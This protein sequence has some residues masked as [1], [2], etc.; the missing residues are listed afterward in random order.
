MSVLFS[1]IPLIAN[2]IDS[3]SIS[4]TYGSDGCIV[5]FLVELEELS[6]L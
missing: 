6:I 3:V 5:S 2:L 4:T 1:D